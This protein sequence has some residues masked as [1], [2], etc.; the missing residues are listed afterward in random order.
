MGENVDKWQ[1]R[2]TTTR[3]DVLHPLRVLLLPIVITFLA[4]IS[5]HV[6]P[7]VRLEMFLFLIGVGRILL[8]VGGLD[9]YLG[10]HI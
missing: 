1:R 4:C 7:K 9:P 6:F 5:L 8:H 3:L 10:F 2:R